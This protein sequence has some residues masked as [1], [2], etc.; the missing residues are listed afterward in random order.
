MDDYII[1]MLD[2]VNWIWVLKW[3]CQDEGVK[4]G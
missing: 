4:C 2:N 3:Y 1:V